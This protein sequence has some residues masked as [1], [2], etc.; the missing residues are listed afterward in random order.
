MQ[1]LRG[2][3]WCSFGERP[4]KPHAKRVKLEELSKSRCCLG[5][6]FTPMRRSF[7]K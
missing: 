7:R 5:D 2:R 6:F 1:R 4:R 3:P